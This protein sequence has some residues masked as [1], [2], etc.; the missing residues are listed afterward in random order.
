MYYFVGITLGIISYITPL[1]TLRL[2]N[3]FYII[4][5]LV[6][7]IYLFKCLRYMKAILSYWVRYETSIIDDMCLKQHQIFMNIVSK[8]SYDNKK[9]DIEEISAALDALYKDRERITQINKLGYNF[10]EFTIYIGSII[11][12][13]L[14]LV[15]QLTELF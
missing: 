15:E 3:A 6:G 12:P 14:T 4:L 9:N 8:E 2:E 11:L 10:K 1:K 7:F 5:L 13:I